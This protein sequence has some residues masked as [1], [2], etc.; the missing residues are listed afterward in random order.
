MRD[1]IMLARLIWSGVCRLAGWLAFP[2]CVLLVVAT[3][4]GVF[5]LAVCFEIE[6]RRDME[7][8]AKPQ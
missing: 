8:A 3:A 2:F 7:K 1:L 5:T 4:A 6:V